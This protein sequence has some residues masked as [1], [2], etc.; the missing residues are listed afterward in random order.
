[1]AIMGL[2]NSDVLVRFHEAYQDEEMFL[3]IMEYLPGGTLYSRQRSS[4]FQRTEGNAAQITRQIVEG[5]AII[6]QNNI[7]HRDIKLENIFMRSSDPNDY[8]I[9]IGDFDLAS[10]VSMVNP[11]RQCGTPGYMPPEMFYKN[12]GGATAKTDV[13]STGVVLFVLYILV[14]ALAYNLHG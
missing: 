6:H 7:L 13:F 5:L 3:I 4:S 2:F 12:Y 8:S 14:Y 11:R 10:P 1:M 9:K